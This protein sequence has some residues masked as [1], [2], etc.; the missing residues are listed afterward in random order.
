MRPD[1]TTS[2]LLYPLWLLSIL[3]VAISELLP[4]RFVRNA[5]RRKTAH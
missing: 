4:A 2:R 3:A 5:R 1:L